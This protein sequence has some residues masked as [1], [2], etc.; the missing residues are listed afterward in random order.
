MQLIFDIEG[1]GLT[2]TKIHCMAYSTPN[3]I[4][5]ATSSYDEMR[6]LL[7]EATTLIGH[8]IILFDIPVLER[9]LNIKIKAKLYDTLGLAWTL[10]PSRIQY[11]LEYF[12]LDY[13]VPKPKIDD[14]ENLSLAEYIH[15]C[16]EDVKITAR[17]WDDLW[18]KLMLLYEDEKAARRYIA[19]ISFKLDCMREQER[20]QWKLDVDRVKRNIDLLSEKEKEILEKL[21][22]VMPKVPKYIKKTKPA[23]P[24]KKDGTYSTFGAKWFALLKEQNLPKDFDGEIEILHHWDE[25]NP[26]SNLQI[27]DWLFSLGWEPE[28]FKYD[29][30][31]ETG[32]ERQIPQVRIDGD[33]GKELCPSVLKIAEDHPEIRLLEGLTT[34]Q[35]RL[36]IFKGFINNHVNGWLVAGMS[37]FTNTLRFKHKNIVNLPGVDKPYGEEIRGSLIAPEGKILCGSDMVSLEEN[38][39]KHYMYPHDP[40]YV[41]EMSKPGFD[42]HLD[43]AKFSHVVT[44]EEI[45]KYNEKIAEVVEKLYPIRKKFKKTNYSATYGIGKD[46]LGRDANIPVKEAAQL[47]DMFWKRNWAITAVAEETYVKHLN[48]EMWLYNPVSNFYYSLRF[49]KD[50]FSTLNQ[51]TGVFCFDSWIKEVRKRRSQMTGQFHDEGI[52]CLKEGYEE[53]M[54]KLLKDS[55][56]A[57]NDKLQLNIQ[58]DVDIQFGKTYAQIH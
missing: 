19:Y 27:K 2:P 45:N 53:R 10:F 33:D 9:I 44:Q 47:L 42:A 17:L 1:D 48:G 51:G 18:N 52:W 6:K 12:G 23:K 37:G 32:V 20:S 57:V 24:F 31:K 49:E 11:G 16:K 8:N 15:R 39:K 21:S 40:E 4:V 29:K 46:K 34:I 36:G 22:A 14:W 43:L 5:K 56:K 38:T 41:K 7:S 3:G 28:T 25:P 35:H 26:G 55:I 13:G 30:N 58:L 50:I 54:T